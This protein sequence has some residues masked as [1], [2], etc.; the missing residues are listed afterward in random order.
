MGSLGVFYTAIA[1]T[2]PAAC[3]WNA[4]F[5]GGFNNQCRI[6]TAGDG[7]P[8]ELLEFSIEQMP[9]Q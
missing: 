1:S 4:S 2:S 8:V 5:G 6:D 7:L 3:Q 9:V